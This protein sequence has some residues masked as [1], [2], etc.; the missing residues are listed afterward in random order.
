MQNSWYTLRLPL[1]T[2]AAKDLPRREILAQAK[3]RKLPMYRVYS[4]GA[5][6]R[7]CGERS[8]PVRDFGTSEA[9]EAADVSCVLRGRHSAQ[10]R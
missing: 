4:E 10:M 3:Q 1:R 7:R 9:A 5:I 8:A 6:L 2:D